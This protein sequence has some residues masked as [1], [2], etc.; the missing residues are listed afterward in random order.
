MILVEIV[1]LEQLL[2]G[3]I[4]DDL[5]VFFNGL[6]I[7]PFLIVYVILVEVYLV[8]IRHVRRP[9][10]AILQRG[11]VE[12]LEPWV[13]LGLVIAVVAEAR[14][15]HPVE[16]FVDEVGGLETP[17]V[18]HLRLVDL[19]LVLFDMVAN[20]FT[21]LALIRPA[22]IHALVS[23]DADGEIVGHHTVIVL[24]HDFGRH[25]T[26]SATGLVRVVDAVDPF[27]GD[28]EVCQ[29]EVA[30]V[31]K[32]KILGLYITMDDVGAVHGLQSLN[33]ARAEELR[34]FLREPLLARQMESKI[35]TQQ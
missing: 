30:V 17:P 33:E 5:H 12:V 10:T 20:V 32:D 24:A 21:G 28:T 4:H 26:G 13:V 19:G 2:R 31:V 22:P 27:P 1:A 8:L 11:P 7:F 6:G 34:L 29:L 3:R 9:H 25:V 14:V 15:R 23:D 18:G 16:A 35:T